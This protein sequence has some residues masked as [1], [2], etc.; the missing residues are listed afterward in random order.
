MSTSTITTTPDRGVLA[1]GRHRF[2]IWTAGCQMNR[3]DSERLAR[4]LVSAGHVPVSHPDRAS[5][6]VLNGCSVRD[7]SDRKTYG[8]IGALGARKRREPDLMVALTG[9]S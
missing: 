4:A 2:F 7:N 5:F 1:R 9:C 8:R 3:D 6:V